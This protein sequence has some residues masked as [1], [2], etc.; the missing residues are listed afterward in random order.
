MTF[1]HALQEVLARYDDADSEHETIKDQIRHEY[2]DELLAILPK[3]GQYAVK[4]S[5]GMGSTALI[6]W[7]A[8]FDKRISDAA[9]KGFYL[10]YLFKADRTGVYLSFL[11]SWTE[12]SNLYK[13]EI[14]LEN[15][16]RIA[17]RTWSSVSSSLPNKNDLRTS[18]DLGRVGSRNT[19]LARGYEQGHVCGY[20]YDRNNIPSD[21][22][23]SKDL[24]SMLSIYG[25]V[26]Q[27]YAE[28]IDDNAS[29]ILEAY[30]QSIP[31]LCNSE[32]SIKEAAQEVHTEHSS[33]ASKRRTTNNQKR[34]STLIQEA[35]EVTAVPSE[36]FSAFKTYLIEKEH[37]SE[38]TAKTYAN[39]FKKQNTFY[40]LYSRLVFTDPGTNKQVKLANTDIKDICT[41]PIY[42]LSD[43]TSVCRLLLFIQESGY[44]YVRKGTGN[45][46][47]SDATRF[48]TAL[49]YYEKFLISNIPVP[50]TVLCPGLDHTNRDDKPVSTTPKKK[51]KIDFV[52]KNIRNIQLGK[53]GESLEIA[54]Q[55][56]QLLDRGQHELADKVRP[57]SEENDN[58]GYDILSFDPETGEELHIEVK[59]TSGGLDRPFYVSSHEVIQ[60]HDDHAFMLVR[61]YD[62]YSEKP[63]RFENRGDLHGSAELIPS[64]Y[65]IYPDPIKESNNR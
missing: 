7:I 33:G 15:I 12:F 43:V 13:G 48:T 61:Y 8:A 42:E 37:L 58:A 41:T 4:G 46:A 24:K 2:A 9:S 27:T 45:N 40:S 3:Q 47:E 23:L 39:E 14:A 65:I 32:I 62:C 53:F 31:I 11:L 34:I 29:T 60:S 36:Q 54:F 16:R 5:A 6:P 50:E 21:E 52:Q 63:K 56:R 30:E 19:T 55:K 20:Y 51:S 22:Q 44:R 10:V 59:T 25:K 38:D 17:D 18:I 49:K 57:I 64:S 35:F 28:K 1:Q 26:I